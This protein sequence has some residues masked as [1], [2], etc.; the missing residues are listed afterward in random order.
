MLHARLQT[1]PTGSPDSIAR[2]LSSRARTGEILHTKVLDVSHWWIFGNVYVPCLHCL[3]RRGKEANYGSDYDFP[4]R[5]FL[6]F[7]FPL[8]DSPF[9]LLSGNSQY[10]NTVTP[11]SGL[12]IV[13]AKCDIIHLL[14][15]PF[16]H[17]TALILPAPEESGQGQ[18]SGD[19]K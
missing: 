14:R 8:L 16:V 9:V 13:T 6:P 3:P 19:G 18:Q 4:I 17:N 5:T 12:R 11:L 7:F 2:G 1:I 15:L 10:T